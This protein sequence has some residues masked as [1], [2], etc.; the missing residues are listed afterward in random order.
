[1]KAFRIDHCVIVADGSE[2]AGEFYLREISGRPPRLVEE[3]ASSHGILCA[4]GEV[5]T[6]RTVI[7]EE[8]DRRSEWLRMGVPCE[9]HWPFLVEEEAGGPAAGRVPELCP[10]TPKSRENEES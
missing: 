6:V 5:R 1:M 3:L 4:D 8:M 10:E 7:N 2:E 9:L